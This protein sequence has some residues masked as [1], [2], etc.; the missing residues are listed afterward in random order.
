[1]AGIILSAE[2]VEGKLSKKVQDFSKELGV[3]YTSIYLK[4]TYDPAI[5]KLVYT[6]FKKETDKDVPVRQLSVVKDILEIK[7][8]LFG[9]GQQVAMFLG[10][11]FEGYLRKL[12]CDIDQLEILAIPRDNEDS[13]VNFAVYNNKLFVEWI[14]T[15]NISVL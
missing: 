10:A 8:D 12:G 11:I 6:L 2:E 1:M 3:P 9:K 4:I 7:A 5:A 13:S 15:E 14:D